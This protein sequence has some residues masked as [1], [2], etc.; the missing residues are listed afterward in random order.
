MWS[1]LV[2]LVLE[3]M[4]VGIEVRKNN[5]VECGFHSFQPVGKFI[6]ENNHCF[7]L[8]DDDM[9]FCD[10]CVHEIDT[11]DY[12][13]ISIPMRRIPH[14]LLEIVEEEVKSLL[15]ARVIRPA[16][17]EWAFSIVPVTRRMDR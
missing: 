6:I 7:S 12:P 16:F 13:P 17:S 8:T 11:G 5:H 2:Q 15:R 14:V 3:E 4:E 1:D 9:G 10:V